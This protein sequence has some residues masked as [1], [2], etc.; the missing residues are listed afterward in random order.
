LIARAVLVGLV[1]AGRPL[2]AA[3]TLPFGPGER[4]GMRVTYAKLTAGR[5]VIA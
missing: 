4:I 3:E 2:A 5:A 1:L